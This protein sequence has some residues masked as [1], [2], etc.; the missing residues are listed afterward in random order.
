MSSVGTGHTDP[1]R[2]H[3]AYMRE[4]THALAERAFS[5]VRSARVTPPPHVRREVADTDQGRAPE[6]NGLHCRFDWAH[7]TYLVIAAVP[8]IER[9]LPVCFAL[10]GIVAC[11]IGLHRA[12]RSAR[13]GT[14]NSSLALSVTILGLTDTSCA[15]IIALALIA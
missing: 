14:G 9:V 13:T 7:R 11:H 15:L 2:R 5:T 6:T 10:G 3:D 12:L 1:L 4:V 8:W